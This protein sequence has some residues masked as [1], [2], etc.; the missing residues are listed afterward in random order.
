MLK[1]AIILFLFP[2]VI[3][4]QTKVS[5]TEKYKQIGLVWGLLKYHHPD[6]SRGMYNWDLELISFL[7]SIN[8]IEEQEKLNTK[9]NSF[10]SKYNKAT[11]KHKTISLKIDSEKIF[12]K[13]FNYD[14]I[15]EFAFTP[16]IKSKL[17]K[18]KNNGNIGD[19]YAS[20]SK[21]TKMISFSNEKGFPN[22]NAK[23]KNHRL[24][25][26]YSYWNIIQYWNVNKYLTDIN[27][28]DT[29]DELIKNFVNANTIQEY[30]ISKLNM[31]ALLND[32][33]SY[34]TSTYFYESLFKYSP[35]FG[36]KIINDSLLVTS[37]YNKTLAENNNIDLG[38]IIVKIN[39]QNIPDYIRANFS[40]L[41]SV[42]NETYLKHRLNRLILRNSSDSLKIHSLDKDGNLKEKK[43]K[44]F[45]SFKVDGYKTLV[46]TE[47]ADW[48]KVSS[49]ITYINLA[50][51]NSKEFSKVLK[52]NENDDGIILDLR[53]YP[54]NL[55]LKDFSKHLFPEKK[56]FIKILIPLDKA[57]SLGE[58]PASA[59]LK[60]IS[61]PFE[62]GK[63][64]SNYFKG[65][66]ILLVNRQ[67]G[68]MAEYF[69]MAIQ[70]SPNCITI[71]EQTMGAVMNITSAI[72]PD[73]QE[74]YFT[75]I[76]AFYPNGD[77]V[78]RKGLYI[79]YYIKESI[80]N[81]DSKLYIDKAIKIIKENK[82]LQN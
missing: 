61:N 20:S 25:E 52:E 58:Y 8:H 41:I 16:E 80:K 19:Y 18:L 56:E 77:M 74:F 31:F 54:R 35:P 82:H 1:K 71:G 15:D 27:W 17:T 46:K 37:I 7:D 73:K 36:I 29:L 66:I 65:K 51:I 64:N 32:S 24:L 79:D 30:E 75:G 53:N 81:Y 26:L 33:H 47:K 60:F 14:W 45:N 50:N 59:P 76:G 34:K 55:K 13:N 78:Q 12:R 21:L 6:I 43:I 67:T 62:I 22:F 38:E 72:L 57:P 49:K 44:L 4:S 70:Q 11:T 69:G 48:K 68:S 5:Q 10:I 9:L 40:K 39:N 3:Y 2:F 23:L 42:S 28:V 63:R